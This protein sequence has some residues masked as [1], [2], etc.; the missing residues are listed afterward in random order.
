MQSTSQN[1]VSSQVFERV[2]SIEEPGERYLATKAFIDKSGPWITLDVNGKVAMVHVTSYLLQK[3]MASDAATLLKNND[4]EGWL[5]YKFNDGVANDF[6]FALDSDN[7]EYLDALIEH[8][9]SGINTPFKINLAGNMATPIGILA[10]KRYADY[11]GY[12]LV[13]T[14]ML[15]A[16]ANP[17]QKLPSGIS[18]MIIA[19]SSNNMDFVRIAQTHLSKQDST[20]KGL[21]SNTPLES[22]QLF[23][24]QAIADALIE[25]SVSETSSYDEERLHN[26]WV[27]MIIKGYNVPADL[28]YDILSKREGFNIDFKGSGGLSALMASTLSDLYGGNVEY[29]I[30]L[31]ARGADPKILTNVGSENGSDVQVN[32]IQLSLQKDNHKIVALLIGEN[33]N[34]IHLPDNEDIF[35]LAQ[36]LEQKAYKSSYI[37]KE[38]L[39]RAVSGN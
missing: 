28:I 38:A 7:I 19:S 15:N 31:I 32:L 14:K 10:S 22:E 5:S 35:I 16:G 36:A 23:E 30:K 2:I 1:G 13:L 17:H 33:V 25:K 11:D 27:Q 8:A 29:A 26:I 34:Y 37:L 18:P 20:V 21:L 4:V 6:M 12:E 24:M 39:M 3:D 9:P